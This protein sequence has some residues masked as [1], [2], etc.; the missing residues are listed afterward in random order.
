MTT[1]RGVSTVADVSLALFLIVAAV[2]VLVAFTETDQRAHE[3]LETDHTGQTLAASTMN[4]SYNVSAAVETYYQN[5]RPTAN[6]YDEQ[7]M[8][9]I[10]HGPMVT[11]VADIAATTLVI[12]GE[13]LTKEATDYERAVETQLETRLVG[14]QF[15]T[16]VSAYWRPLPG[17]DMYSETTVGQQAPPTADVSTTTMTVSSGMPDARADALAAVEGE[18]DYEAVAQ[19]VADAIVR[20][21]FPPL[22]TQ[23]ALERSGIDYVLTS[24]R[25]RRMATI[26]DGNASTLEANNWLTPAS[27][28]ATA[29][30]T[31]LRRQLAATL[32]A[33]LDAL[34]H[35]GYESAYEAARA[36]STGTITVTIRT[37]TD[38]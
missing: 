17:V 19:A 33:K 3:P 30:N 2:G 5:Y 15:D 21:Q 20:G 1:A 16:S 38:D 29:A 9:R 25:Y 22:E 23:R 10:S 18:R 36:V 34:H 26:L 37:W 8:R 11:Q 28:N 27:A 6:P 14:S 31:Y 4:T 7:E 32:E 35:D 12:D 13:L 24:Y